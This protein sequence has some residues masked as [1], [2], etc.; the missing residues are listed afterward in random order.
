MNIYVADAALVVHI[1][2]GQAPYVHPAL[3]V[4]CVAAFRKVVAPGPLSTP[5]AEVFPAVG[6]ANS[7]LG[8]AVRA[9]T[10]RKAG[11]AK[12]PP[13]F[14]FTVADENVRAGLRLCSALRTVIVQ[15]GSVQHLRRYFSSLCAGVY[16]AE[17]NSFS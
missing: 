9:H 14:T 17:V 8:D 11:D 12:S 5:L 4:C 16:E 6:V 2:P 3:A 10:L 13:G 7:T 15:D 1:S